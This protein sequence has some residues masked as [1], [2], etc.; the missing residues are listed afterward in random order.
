[1]GAKNPGEWSLSFAREL[2]SG[3]GASGTTSAQRKRMLHRQRQLIEQ[4]GQRR[5]ILDHDLLPD[6]EAAVLRHRRCPPTRGP[7]LQVGIVTML[8]LD[9]D[10]PRQPRHRHGNDVW[11]VA[12]RRAVLAVGDVQAK[13]FGL[14]PTL[15]SAAS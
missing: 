3:S 9:L 7:G 14:G 13:V 10:R 12:R 1:M 2:K 8:A 11:L 4:L 15:C 5:R 6:A